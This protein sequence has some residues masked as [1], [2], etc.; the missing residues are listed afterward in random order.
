MRHY[1]QSTGGVLMT[2]GAIIVPDVG[3]SNRRPVARRPQS[4]GPHV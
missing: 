4:M 1:S 3:P 2:I